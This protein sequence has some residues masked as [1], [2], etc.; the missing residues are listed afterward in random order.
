[1]ETIN[2]DRLNI[3]RFTEYDLEDLYEYLSDPEVVR[4]E[5]YDVMDHDAAAETLKLRISSDEFFAVEETA[6]GKVIGNIYLGKGYCEYCY[7]LGY[8]FNRRYWGQGYAYEASSAVI[9]YVFNNGAH[10]IEAN[11]DPNNPRSWRLLERLGFVREG[12]LKRDIFFRR[13]ED[14]TPIWKDTY[15][16]SRLNLNAD[17]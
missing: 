12:H 14:G 10:R 5:P 3:R 1:M 11:C 8:V 7:E 2:T 4:F 13:D 16:Y 17:I 9:E 15:I 6:S